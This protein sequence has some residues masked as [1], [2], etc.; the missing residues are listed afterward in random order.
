M[1]IH[2][3]PESKAESQKNYKFD[4]AGIISFMITMVALQLFVTQGNKL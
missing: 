4:F 1:L 3:T 2:G